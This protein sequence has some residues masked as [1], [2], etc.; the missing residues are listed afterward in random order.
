M[1]SALP[2]LCCEHAHDDL[3]V[4]FVDIGEQQVKNI[5]R[6][7]RVYRV[8]LGKGDKEPKAASEAPSAALDA[9]SLGS[10]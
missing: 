10:S 7:I 5:V 4:S 1:A 2:R 3:G 9:S 8:T 6:P